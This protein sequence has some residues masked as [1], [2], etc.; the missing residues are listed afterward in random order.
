MVIGSAEKEAPSRRVTGPVPSETA[1]CL[2]QLKLRPVLTEKSFLLQ[3]L[4]LQPA[5][6]RLLDD[7]VGT[8]FAPPD[9]TNIGAFALGA[10]A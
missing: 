4:M 9:P 5:I 1:S 2:P 7:H 3:L 8:D 6:D 10:S